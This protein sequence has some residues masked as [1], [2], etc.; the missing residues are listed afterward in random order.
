[1]YNLRLVSSF[2]PFD[3]SHM[4]HPATSSALPGLPSGDT[5]AAYSS[6]VSWPVALTISSVISDGYTATPVSLPLQHEN[7]HDLESNLTSRCKDIEAYLIL[8][9][10]CGKLLCHMCHSSLACRIR[11]MRQRDTAKCSDGAGDDHL[12]T[13]CNISN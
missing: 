8:G 7:C 2:P 6:E 11:K 3:A 4:M 12:A 1:M 9:K 13:L 10:R 5:R